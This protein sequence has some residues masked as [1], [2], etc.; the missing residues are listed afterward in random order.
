MR[1]GGFHPGE[2]QLQPGLLQGPGVRPVG[3]GQRVLVGRGQLR[4]VVR[5]R[6]VVRVQVGHAGVLCDGGHLVGGNVR[7][8]ALLQRPQRAG[9]GR[10]LRPAHVEAGGRARVEIR[11]RGSLEGARLLVER[12]R[13]VVLLLRVHAGAGRARAALLRS[14]RPFDSSAAPAGAA[15]A[16]ARS[17]SPLAHVTAPRP[18]I[19]QRSAIRGSPGG[20]VFFRFLPGVAAGAHRGVCRR[21]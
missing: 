10:G 9:V 21:S 1:F 19:G 11:R 17:A 8:A 16:R 5:V 18:P 2:R 3:E 13:R 15:R 7:R 20:A 12:R 6:V 14:E 4:M